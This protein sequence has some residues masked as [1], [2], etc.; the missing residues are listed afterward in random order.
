VTA[1]AD[2]EI[3]Q[4][5]RRI[6][7]ANPRCRVLVT[8][9]YAQRAPQEIAT[10]EGVAWVVGNS[11]K[12]AIAP[13]LAAEFPRD[14]GAGQHN[15][16]TD[17]LPEPRPLVQIEHAPKPA[18]A[19]AAHAAR[20]QVLVGEISESFHFAP[21]RADDRTRPTLKIQDGCNARCSFCIIPQVR[22]GSRS[23]PPDTVINEARR[24]HQAGYQELVLSG[25]NLGSYGRDLNRSITL[26]GLLERILAHTS[27]RRL[28][29]S[30]IEPMDVTPELMALMACELRLAQHFHIPLQSGCDRILRLM[31]RR[32]WTAQYAQR[33]LAIRE[34]IPNC[35]I[36]ADVMVGFPGETDR[37]H[38]E[39]MRF[40]ESLPLT[41]VHVFP[42]S[43]RP[44]TPAAG[45]RAQVNGRVSHERGHEIR[46]EVE[47]KRQAF[48][49]A[50]IG[51]TVSALTLHDRSDAQSTPA[52]PSMMALTTNYLRMILPE[53]KIPPN[54]LL[55]ARLA[56][57]R[58]GFLVGYVEPSIGHRGAE[59]RPLPALPASGG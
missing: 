31:N 44:N 12:H 43:Q 38:Q 16:S 30:S 9:C 20:P 47:K 24:L 3:R 22:G 40:I 51:Q 7:R 21:A 13:L 32:Y 33:V 28:R 26:L 1:A 15:R 19:P 46:T 23:L 49:A 6:R 35:G 5:V 59:C 55:E 27:I 50:Q 2:A 52:G 39:S 42:Y 53:A 58:A 54:T 25:I 18:A 56:G 4:V 10:L 41:Y 11:H 45:M 48:M 17:L 57:V 37:D 34:R 29:I 8:G 36:G 14:L